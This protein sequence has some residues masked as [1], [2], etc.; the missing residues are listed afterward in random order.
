MTELRIPIAQ[1][2]DN[3][4]QLGDLLTLVSATVRAPTSVTP[5]PEVAYV[6][7]PD[8]T[9]AEIALVNAAIAD[10]FGTAGS[11]P[12]VDYRA[13]RQNLRILR[14]LRQAGRNAYVGLSEGDRNRQTFDCL[15]A[16]TEILLRS[17]RIKE[18]TD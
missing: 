3:T 4:E 9:Q 14:D 17:T 12:M 16:I 2:E 18:P 11:L 6:F 10:V 7:D 5:P 1:G 8:L 15:I 13:I